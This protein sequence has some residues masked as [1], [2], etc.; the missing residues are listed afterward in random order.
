[1]KYIFSRIFDAVAGRPWDN[2]G[3][4]WASLIRITLA[5]VLVA[6]I[7]WLIGPALQLP[8][9]VGHGYPPTTREF[10]LTWSSDFR[11][12]ILEFWQRSPGMV[13]IAAIALAVDALLLVP[14]Y[15]SAF[16]LLAQC[17]RRSRDALDHQLKPVAGTTRQAAVAGW[18]V[19]IGAVSDQFENLLSIGLVVGADA[20][21][22]A[23]FLGWGLAFF[24]W[25]KWL[26]LFTSL[27][28]CLSLV[29]SIARRLGWKA[30]KAQLLAWALIAAH[31]VEMLCLFGFAIGSLAVGIVL[32]GFVPQ[33]QDVLTSLGLDPVSSSVAN[34][35]R[36]WNL[37]WLG[38]GVLIWSFALWMGLWLV[39]KLTPADPISGEPRYPW[40]RYHAPR[41]VSF[42]G[43]VAVA[44]LCAL[45]MSARASF[46]MAT[47]MCLG[48]IIMFD[49]A[50]TLLSH[51]AHRLSFYTAG[52]ESEAPSYRRS[53]LGAAVLALIVA[54]VSVG[55]DPVPVLDDFG[56]YMKPDRAWRWSA[57]KIT[58]QTLWL[59]VLFFGAAIAYGV[60]H[61]RTTSPRVHLALSFFAFL[62]WWTGAALVDS[63]LAVVVFGLVLLLAA[64]G[65]WFLIDRRHFD[66]NRIKWLTNV[67][68]AAVN[69]TG[70]V[71]Q[72]PDR[73]I[74]WWLIVGAVTLVILFSTKPLLGSAIGTLGVGFLALAMWSL[75][76]AWAFI[77]W[78]KR[79]GLGNWMIVPIIWVVVFGQQADH[80]LRV[81][82]L[83]KEQSSTRVIPTIQ[84][85]FTEWRKGL[86]D[87]NGS[88]VFFVAASGGGLRAAY[89]TATLL[90]AMDDR[91]CGRFGDHVFAVSGVS[92]GSLGLAAYL[93]QRKVWSVKPDPQKCQP[94]RVEE[95]QRFL[96]RDYLGPVAGSLLFAEAVQAFIPF[97]Y[98][99]Q[100]RGRTLADSIALGWQETYRG[101]N[102]RLLE[103]PFLELFSAGSGRGQVPAIYLNATGV[104]SGRRV[105]ASN[106]QLGSVLAD[107]L[108][109]ES[110]I[111]RGTRLQT[112]G[113]SAIDAVVNSARFPGVSPPGRVWGCGA[114]L[115]R[116]KSE[117]D[118]CNGIG[119]GPWGHVV[120]GGFFENSG[121]E[122]LMDVRR[123]LFTSHLATLGGGK[124]PP[125]FVI[126]ISN[127]TTYRNECPGLTPR[128]AMTGH[129]VDAAQTVN[130]LIG[131]QR[132]ASAEPYS[133]DGIGTGGSDWGAPL[134]ALLSVREGRSQLE[135]RRAAEVVGC[136]YFLEWSLA[137]ETPRQAM[138]NP[139]LGWLL[140]K[141]SV[142]LMDAGVERYAAAFPFDAL[143]CRQELVQSRGWL[144][145]A[146]R[147]DGASCP[148]VST[149]SAR[150]IAR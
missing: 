110:T 68:N 8:S 73:N 24:A 124:L 137:T 15:V 32:V 69:M 108:F 55:A 33:T 130:A 138:K 17:L 22:A 106:V 134:A 36:I 145:R 49:V 59:V 41:V 9:Q 83:R 37:F 52:V 62:C 118:H 16:V 121:L 125:V 98:L 38:A 46:A 96:G 18:A 150:A 65:L 142:G 35:L 123:E 94:G 48:A 116:S 140:S 14:L 132:R 27:A 149:R 144:G 60:N 64:T 139:P 100:E 135:S 79:L 51:A 43:L 5:A 31:T 80:S 93:A 128:Y 56:W 39:A 97:T 146:D 133:P 102:S 147:P 89:W 131:A 40:A 50:S 4:P 136:P 66:A 74:G 114:T 6:W 23:A 77:Y 127:D 112:A 71:L 61:L 111:S 88:P 26:L 13:F 95:M 34:Q 107:P 42:F 109:Y 19:L 119:Y 63:E 72:R 30:I 44:T 78:P 90:A 143:W 76:L 113:L 87:P 82:P 10:Q 67:A 20:S 57:S 129:D 117:L 91:T 1:M 84:T 58:A 70:G 21:S 92:G 47:F 45:H 99:E 7:I 29:W 105:I 148:S 115:D 141:R 122:T 104:E 54:W 2:S 85:H 75:L 103:Q 86:P 81:A 53:V 11:G 28:A 12:A 101:E 3:P 25:A 120:D 126:T